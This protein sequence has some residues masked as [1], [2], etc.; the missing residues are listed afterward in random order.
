M[1][2]ARPPRHAASEAIA[3]GRGAALRA[4][5]APADFATVWGVRH[6]DS[7]KPGKLPDSIP[8]DFV[9]HAKPEPEPEGEDDV[10]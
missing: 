3:R 4:D 5:A 7:D 1:P 6:R 10:D 8:M 9:V 2:G